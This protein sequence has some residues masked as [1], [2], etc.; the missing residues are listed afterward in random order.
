MNRRA[1]RDEYLNVHW[2][3]PGTDPDQ[4]LPVADPTERCFVVLGTLACL[5]YETFKRGAGH[6]LWVH[7][8]SRKRPVLCFSRK[9]KRLVIAGGSYTVN[10]RGIVG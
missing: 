5:G 4:V 8:F 7:E 2:G 6:A 9:T 3:D 10:E 1:A